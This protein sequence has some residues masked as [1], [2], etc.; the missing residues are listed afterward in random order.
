MNAFESHHFFLEDVHTGYL[1]VPLR[2]VYIYIGMYVLVSV[3]G[4]VSLH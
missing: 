3:N 4:F 2:V 1:T